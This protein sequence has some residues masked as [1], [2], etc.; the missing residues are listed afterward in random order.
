MTHAHCL[1]PKDNSQVVY[2]C[3]ECLYQLSGTEMF[4]IGKTLTNLLSDI[5][6]HFGS[7]ACLGFGN[8]LSS[9]LDK[10]FTIEFQDEQLLLK[11][12][13]LGKVAI[14]ELS[15]YIKELDAKVK[16][17]KLKMSKQLAKRIEYARNA[18]IAN[19]ITHLG[20]LEDSLG[21]DGELYVKALVFQKMVM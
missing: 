15:I 16:L 10:C 21:K 8:I 20:R 2:I 17:A 14:V 13:K 5:D 19:Y 11:S 4:A 18:S 6:I 3:D 12:R 7:L 1:Q 9:V